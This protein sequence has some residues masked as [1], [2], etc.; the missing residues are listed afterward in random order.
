MI[1]YSE[2][3]RHLGN[4]DFFLLAF[5]PAGEP[6][7]LPPHLS[8]CEECRRRFAEWERA[9]REIAGRPE[10]PEPGFEHAV[11]ARIRRLPAP[12]RRGMRRAWAGGL[13]AAACLVAAFWA[14]T[15][16]SVPADD[17]ADETARSMS[18]ADRA[19]DALL[20]DVSRL[21]DEEE[22]PG[23]KALAPLPE[24]RGGNS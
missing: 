12:R 15:R 5:P 24:G 20:R 19:D 1:V 6:E 4:D 23:W 16:V 9:A 14:G 10:T 21:V 3:D 11:M 2:S 17:R 22:G 13:A 18:A 8:R 7:G